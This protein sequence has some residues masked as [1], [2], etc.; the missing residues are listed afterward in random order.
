MFRKVGN[1]NIVTIFC[2]T[3]ME[4]NMNDLNPLYG[5]QTK[6]SIS[7]MSFSNKKL[8]NFPVYIKSISYVKKAC[9]IA[10]FRAGLLQEHIMQ[11]ITNACDIIIKG[12]N[13]LHFPVDV[14]SGGGGIAIN[15]NVNEVIASLAGSNVSPVNHVNMSQSTSDVCHTSLRLSL[16]H[17]IKFLEESLF[18]LISSL[19]KK[20]HEFENINTIARTCW[21]DGMQVSAGALFTSTASALKRQTHLYGHYRKTLTEINLGWT[22]IGT[23]TG[24][25]YKYR[26]HILQSLKE[27]FEY[28]F[29]YREDKGDSSQYPDDIAA[30]SSAIRRTSEILS[31]L[32]KDLRILSSG[33][34]TGLGE[35]I[36]PNIQA[37]SSFFPGKSNPIIPE[38]IIQCAMLISGND[39]IIQSQL[40]NGEVHLNVW[41][42][43][44]GFLLLENLN[45][46]INATQILTYKCIKQIQINKTVC[47][48][49]ANSTMPLLVKYKEELGYDFVVNMIKKEGLQNVITKI[50]GEQNE[51]V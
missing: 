26:E 3:S 7:N 11:Q 10:N 17:S 38:T 23:G 8:S 31:K 42:P 39:S 40:G 18:I 24:A 19:Y 47:E 32:C 2:N 4:L 48:A 16:S 51:T 14:Y 45:M 21:Q 27:V 29:T 30:L 15:M 41:E 33:P 36:L 5:E 44:M 46:L 6:L 22:V 13:E 28:E 25:S 49:Y 37:G 34:E 12:Y 43:M 35:L 20:G 1:L 9:A 50:K